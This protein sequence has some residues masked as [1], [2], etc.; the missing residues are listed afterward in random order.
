MS[1][2]PETGRKFIRFHLDCT[3]SFYVYRPRNGDQPPK[4]DPVSVDPGLRNLAN[5]LARM[6][7]TGS[8]S[9]VSLVCK[10]G[11]IKAHKG[12]LSTRSEVRKNLGNAVMLVILHFF[13][14]QHFNT[15]VAYANYNDDIELEIEIKYF[16]RETMMAL[17][18]F[19][20]TGELP[21]LGS[22]DNDNI[23]ELL[24]AAEHFG[25]NEAKEK[26][27]LV[28][29]KGLNLENVI[30]KLDLAFRYS[31]A[32]PL[33][34]EALAFALDNI[35]ELETRPE[36][37]D[38]KRR[39][40]VICE[41]LLNLTIEKKRKQSDGGTAENHGATAPKRANQNGYPGGPMCMTFI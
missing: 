16:T 15:L 23:E 7:E 10:D 3:L 8:H 25:A 35:V 2:R 27:G 17:L 24:S 14:S 41:D 21:S 6:L 33:K 13:I 36:W 20:Y 32:E 9:D 22:F 1:Q 29:S 4:Q 39:Q 31:L 11:I 12:V 30:R 18:K 26:I 28:L 37:I 34:T 5:D 38:L 19:F 40:P